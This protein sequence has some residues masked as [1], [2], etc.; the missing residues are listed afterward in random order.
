MSSMSTKDFWILAFG[1]PSYFLVGAKGEE[2]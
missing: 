1:L 2:C